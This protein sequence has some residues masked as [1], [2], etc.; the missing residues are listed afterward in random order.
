MIPASI[1]LLMSPL[2]HL[3]DLNLFAQLSFHAPEPVLKDLVVGMSAH[4]CTPQSTDADNEHH[5][6]L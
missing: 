4:A 2:L 6:Y 5:E 3:L 1:I